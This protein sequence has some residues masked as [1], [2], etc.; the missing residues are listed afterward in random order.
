M[1]HISTGKNSTEVVDIPEIF[2]IVCAIETFPL[3]FSFTRRLFF[4]RYPNNPE[5]ATLL[6][7]NFRK[8][9]IEAEKF[10]SD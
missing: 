6:E 3:E 4:L 2:E 1:L 8:E 5:K 10:P 7:N 9:Q